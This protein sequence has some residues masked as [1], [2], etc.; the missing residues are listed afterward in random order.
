MDYRDGYA[1]LIFIGSG[2]VGG[3]IDVPQ[4]GKSFPTAP[5]GILIIRASKFA[6][7]CGP[8]KSGKRICITGFIDRSTHVRAMSKHYEMFSV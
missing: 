1:I 5:G 6:H 4:L 2:W 3:S 7:R 8:I